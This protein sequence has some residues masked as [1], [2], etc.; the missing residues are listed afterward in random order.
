MINNS[1]GGMS[2]DDFIQFMGSLANSTNIVLDPSRAVSMATY[3]S[4]DNKGI[5]SLLWFSMMQT[6]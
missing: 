2:S 4:N 3:S 5:I 1:A 6:H